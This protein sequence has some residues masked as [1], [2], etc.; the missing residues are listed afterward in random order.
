VGSAQYVLFFLFLLSLFLFPTL[1]PISGV[2]TI[3]F[4]HVVIKIR[5]LFLRPAG[6]LTSTLLPKLEI[7][8]FDHQSDDWPLRTLLSFRDSTPSALTAASSISSYH[9]FFF[10][11][12]ASVILTP[13][14]VKLSFTQF[15]H[16]FLGQ[17]LLGLDGHLHLYLLLFSLCDFHSFV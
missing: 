16:L 14:I 17:P 11:H 8:N 12:S 15:I 2:S 10:Y 6:C 9:L 4:H 7:I 13:F 3:C 1:I 5:Q